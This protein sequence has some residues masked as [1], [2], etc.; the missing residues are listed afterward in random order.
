MLFFLLR[1]QH[2]EYRRSWFAG[3]W[4]ALILG[5]YPLFSSV[6]WLALVSLSASTLKLTRAVPLVHYR[7]HDCPHSLLTGS[8][9]LI[10]PRRTVVSVS[11]HTSRFYQLLSTRCCRVVC[12]LEFFR[13][14][15]CVSLSG[16]ALETAK[17]GLV[18]LK[19]C[20]GTYYRHEWK[21]GEGGH[22]GV[23]TPYPAPS[24]DSRRSLHPQCAT[25]SLRF[26]QD[27]QAA[28][29]FHPSYAEYAEFVVP[30]A[31]D[32]RVRFVRSAHGEA[33]AWTASKYAS[34]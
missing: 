6:A 17:M 21:E 12:T 31:H 20:Y 16:P 9:T 32:G 1:N 15:T 8:L 4:D 28:S 27:R 29:A 18:L 5:P 26:D 23:L 14:R 3:L 25:V 34:R 33:S 19:T 24:A 7:R 11:V 22:I 10:F 13:G 30:F 2:H